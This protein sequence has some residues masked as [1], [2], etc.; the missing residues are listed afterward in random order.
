[1]KRFLCASLFALPL[2]LPPG[3]AHAVG[4]N[5][6]WP[7]KIEAGANAYF[8]VQKLPQQQQQ[9][10]PW[11][12]YWPLE[13]HFQMQAPAAYGL[14]PQQQV[15]PP[16]FRPPIPAPYPQFQPPAPTPLPPFQPPVPKPLPGNGMK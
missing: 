5:G 10:G 3:A 2:L 4:F 11:Y 16:S 6:P 13:A 15:L 12:L 1:M 7:Y 14:Y 9:L 8:R